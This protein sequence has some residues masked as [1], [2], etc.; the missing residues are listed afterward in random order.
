MAACCTRPAPRIRGVTELGTRRVALREEGS[1]A[2]V[3]LARLLREAGLELA[4]LVPHALACDSHFAVAQ[5]VQLG[6]ADAG[7]A[8]RAVAIAFG[9]DFVPLVQERFDLA[10]PADL[11]DDPRTLRLLEVLANRSFRREL[12]ELGYDAEHSG[13]L[14]CEL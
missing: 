11:A 14:L 4:Q 3:Q 13:E 7:F 10:V 6:A 5:A 9:L 8:I 12:G 2:R 1:G